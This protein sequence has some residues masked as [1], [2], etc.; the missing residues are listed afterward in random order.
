VLRGTKHASTII[1][2]Q[3]STFRWYAWVL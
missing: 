2:F 3:T 1:L